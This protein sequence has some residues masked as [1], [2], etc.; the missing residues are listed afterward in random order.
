MQEKIK[1]SDAKKYKRNSQG[2]VENTKDC[3]KKILLQIDFCIWWKKLKKDIIQWKEIELRPQR[4]RLIKRANSL[5]K[6]LDIIEITKNNRKLKKIDGLFSDLKEQDIKKI[7][8][9]I[10]EAGQNAC[11]YRT[12]ENFDLPKLRVEKIENRGYK[13]HFKNIFNNKSDHNPDVIGKLREKM[14]F[15]NDKT[16]EELNEKIRAALKE[17]TRHGW[18]N[19][20]IEDIAKKLKRHYNYEWINVYEPKIFY[21][22]D[23]VSRLEL[24]INVPCHIEKLELNEALYKHQNS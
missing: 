11:K 17:K 5:M 20:W 23:G 19:I 6:V 22:E 14:N 4:K 18:W 2:F 9:C 10:L 8:F 16:Q 3:I 1:L 21:V 24:T 7:H 12:K 15:A 13:L